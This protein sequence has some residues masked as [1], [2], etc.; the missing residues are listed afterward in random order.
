MEEFATPSSSVLNLVSELDESKETLF[1]H[2]GPGCPAYPLAL[3]IRKT[4]VP[5]ELAFL[6]RLIGAA[7]RGGVVPGSRGHRLHKSPLQEYRN[8]TPAP[9]VATHK[10]SRIQEFKKFKNSRIQEMHQLH[11]IR[12]QFKSHQSCVAGF[13]TLEGTFQRGP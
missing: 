4:A 2:L 1:C 12:V 10:N 5:G 3:W 8:T 7:V 6:V 13:I 11:Q 9:D